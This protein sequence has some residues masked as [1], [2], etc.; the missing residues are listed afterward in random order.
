MSRIDSQK[1]NIGTSYIIATSDEQMRAKEL[2]DA[3]RL[4]SEIIANANMQA[5]QVIADAQQKAQQHFD[6]AVADANSKVEKIIQDAHSEGYQKGFQEGQDAGRQSLIEQIENLE[7][8]A[9]SEFE[10]KKR[11][12]KSAHTDIVDL[13][14]AISD[15]VCHKKLNIDDEILYEITKQAINQLADK[16]CVKI[17]VNPNMAKKIY[18]ISETLKNEILSLQS[19]KIVEDIGVSEDGTIVES[20]SSRVDNRI[21][22]QID[23]IAQKLLVELQSVSEEKLVSE[24]GQ[25]Q[26]D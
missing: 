7:K 19:I 25:S 8:F 24:I 9:Q 21:S 2:V 17:F 10:I 26:N 18:D 13:V 12:I 23:V 14:V 15:K 11:I 5:Q 1:V 6:D 3:K 22:S 20:I 16:E 4:A